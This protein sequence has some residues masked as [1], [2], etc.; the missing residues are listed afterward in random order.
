MVCAQVADFRHELMGMNEKTGT[1][2]EC[3]DVRPLWVK[4]R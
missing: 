2:Q 1:E 3:E 4:M